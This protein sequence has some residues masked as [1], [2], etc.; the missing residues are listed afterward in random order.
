LDTGADTNTGGRVKRLAKFIGDEPFML[1]YGDGVSD[2]DIKELLKYHQSHGKLATVTAV[3][4]AGRFGSLNI[5]SDGNVNKFQE[6]TEGENSWING[7]FFVFQPEV[8]DYILGDKI[9]LEKEPL[10]KLSSTGQLKA[11]KHHGFWQPMDTMREKV[12]LENLWQSGKAPWKV[13]K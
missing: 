7:G 6:K 4:P 9:L 12:M 1:T 5:R 8:I 13:W 10:E 2:V 11:F 3:R